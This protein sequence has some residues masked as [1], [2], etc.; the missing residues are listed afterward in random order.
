[1]GKA[2]CSSIANNNSALVKAPSSNI[3]G[4]KNFSIDSLEFEGE[5]SSNLFNGNLQGFSNCQIN[6]LTINVEFQ[7][8]LHHRW[9][10]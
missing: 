6:N 1:M 7:A 10:W 8:H 5:S 3:E 9:Y 4:Y 2:I